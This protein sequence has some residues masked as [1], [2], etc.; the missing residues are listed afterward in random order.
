MSGGEA[1]AQEAMNPWARSA[2]FD[3]DVELH[4]AVRVL[5]EAMPEAIVD[6]VRF[7]NE[8]TIHVIASQLREVRGLFAQRTNRFRSTCSAI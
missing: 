7:S 4:P 2:Y 1:V 6:V 3:A 5:R 8:T